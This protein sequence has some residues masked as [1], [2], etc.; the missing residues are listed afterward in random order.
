MH[1]ETHTRT[2]DHISLSSLSRQALAERR[3]ARQ[4]SNMSASAGG[5]GGGG[6]DFEKEEAQEGKGDKDL[7]V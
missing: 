5:A 3:A 6:G 2:D 7:V 4:S 1:F